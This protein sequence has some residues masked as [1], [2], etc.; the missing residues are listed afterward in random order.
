VAGCP[1]ACGR[2]WYGMMIMEE[3][4]LLLG[5]QQ[6]IMVRSGSSAWGDRP[7]RGRCEMGG[8]TRPF[9]RISPSFLQPRPRCDDGVVGRRGGEAGFSC[10]VVRCGAVQ[11]QWCGTPDAARK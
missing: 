1:V 10:V 9:E 3:A 6:Y 11:V 2:F 5:A 7:G 4:P 8:G